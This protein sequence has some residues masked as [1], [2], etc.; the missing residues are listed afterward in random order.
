MLDERVLVQ[1]RPRGTRLG[2]NGEMG[3]EE[4][5]RSVELVS[6]TRMKRWRLDGN[7]QSGN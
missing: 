2:T 6:E 5:T 7:G 1:G 3:I 4:S